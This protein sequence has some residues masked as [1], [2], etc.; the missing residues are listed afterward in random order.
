M[1]A[2][3]PLSAAVCSHATVRLCKNPVFNFIIHCQSTAISVKNQV[4]AQSD[5]RRSY[6]LNVG[7]TTES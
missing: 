1:A 4:I 5:V 6:I 3:R 7:I 2:N